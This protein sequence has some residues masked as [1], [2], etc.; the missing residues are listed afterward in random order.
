MLIW[1]SDNVACDRIPLAMF[2]QSAKHNMR[3][4]WITFAF[5]VQYYIIMVSIEVAI[6]QS[7][8]CYVPWSTCADI[9]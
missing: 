7:Y 9:P 6:A 2:L 8:C 5:T 1:D 3:A 4:L